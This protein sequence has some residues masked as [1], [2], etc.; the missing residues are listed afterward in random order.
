MGGIWPETSIIRALGISAGL[1]QRRSQHSQL[2]NTLR[3]DFAPKVSGMLHHPEFWNDLGDQVTVTEKSHNGTLGDYD[4]TAL[5]TA[6][7]LAAAM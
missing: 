6:L 3:F 7:M 5:V 1:S 2:A 4:A